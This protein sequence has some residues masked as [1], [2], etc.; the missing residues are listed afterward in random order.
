MASS[1]SYRARDND[2]GGLSE[3]RVL[4]QCRTDPED[5][6]QLLPSSSTFRVAA[7]AFHLGLSMLESSRSR[8]KLADMMSGIWRV[9]PA[10]AKKTFTIKADLSK[11]AGKARELVDKFLSKCRSQPPNVIVSDRITGEGLAER[12]NWQNVMGPSTD[13]Y[14]PKWAAILRLSKT[15]VDGAVAAADRGDVPGLQRYLFLLSISMAH[16][17]VHFLTGFLFGDSGRVTPPQINY[18][19]GTSTAESGE[20]GRWWEE[21]FFGCFVESFFDSQDPLGSAQAGILYGKGN[22]R[23][24]KIEPEVIERFLRLDFSKIYT[25]NVQT[26]R[27]PTSAIAMEDVR[28][29]SSNPDFDDLD[30]YFHKINALTVQRVSRG[31]LAEIMQMATQPQLVR[32]S[33]PAG[34]PQT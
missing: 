14:N 15:V 3:F 12:V 7:F 30:E 25:D 17:L 19:P 1:S 24:F 18:P 32:L 26:K 9:L 8:E 22:G 27:F 2:S 10:R 29:P 13:T 33:S 11:E 23:W 5:T 34:P 6:P 28:Q 16:E 21:K 20:A 31:D 4:E